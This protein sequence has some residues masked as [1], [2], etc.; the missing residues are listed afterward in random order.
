LAAL[1]RL[2]RI[3]F[4]RAEALCDFA[5]G[6]ALNPF[7]WLGA[8]GWYFFWIVFGSGIYLYI[9]FDTG[10]TDAYASVEYITHEQW[11]LAGIMRSLH[12]YA[13]DAL[14]IV[15]VLHLLREFSLDRLRGKRFFAWITGVPSIFFIYVCG[16]SGYW[17]VWD[18]LAQ[19]IAIATTEWLDALPFFAEPI[20]NN[21]LDNTTL[22][23]RFFTLMVYIHIFVP[24]VMLLLMWVHVQRH[25][26]ARVNPPRPLALGTAVMLI[27]LSLVHPAISQAPADLDVVPGEVG[28]DWFYL[29]LYPFLDTVPGGQMWLIIIAGFLLLAVMPWLPP[30]RLSP[31]AVVSLDNC[32]GCSRCFDDCPF[33]AI[34]MVA[35]SDGKAY[36]TQAAVNVDN[37]LSC[38]LCVGSCPTATPFRRAGPVVAGIELPGHPVAG[39]R[40]DTLSASARFGDGP[41]VLVYACERCGMG[42][43][44]S[45]A[46]EV[47]TMP[48]VGMLP[49]SF[50]DF[51]LSRGLADGVV[52][53]GCASGDC[54]Y[55]LGDAWTSQRL[56][57]QRDPY[58]RDR[59]DRRRLRHL[60]LRATS[61]RQRHRQLEEFT[62]AL[63]DLPRNEPRRRRRD[64]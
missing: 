4:D 63:A 33:A 62:A 19:Y 37:C 26:R 12:R 31:A 30:A 16:I 27:A 54:Y 51:A 45:D 32:N 52:L 48:C 50:V 22:S 41:R 14:V 42:S 25:A 53:A 36:E 3:L 34:T 55:R 39:L 49:P 61:A 6:Q 17:L 57:G 59:V 44:D 35:R 5:F 43:G 58:L 13:S 56:N 15:V 2:L 21:F 7:A 11:Y 64:A 10:I 29:L 20:A 28:F 9:F 23:G 60:H 38:G 8:L 18:Q 47:L 1:K 46:V 24:L 40:E